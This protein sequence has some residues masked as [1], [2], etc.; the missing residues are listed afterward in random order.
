MALTSVI[1][2]SG[3]L[4]ALLEE[5]IGVNEKELKIVLEDA[6]AVAELV[7]SGDRTAE[8]WNMRRHVDQSLTSDV[9]HL[10][11]TRLGN[12]I[13]L[14]LRK[15]F[16]PL[17]GV[18][19]ILNATIFAVLRGLWRRIDQMWPVSWQAT[20]TIIQIEWRAGERLLDQRVKLLFEPANIFSLGIQ[21]PWTCNEF[22][23][24]P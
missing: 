14:R 10:R 9:E 2:S 24:Q 20:A 16:T 12:Q 4:V 19:G 6:I 18:Q 15:R 22:I 7:R 17:V 21:P 1:V 11:A 23:T 8:A 5:I 3:G 13:C